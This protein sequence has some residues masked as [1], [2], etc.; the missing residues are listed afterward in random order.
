M[1]ERI[2]GI[3]IWRMLLILVAFL[4]HWRF[5]DAFPFLHLAGGVAVNAFFIIGGYFF[6][7]NAQ[8]NGAW[9]TLKKTFFRVMP[10]VVVSGLLF[11]L[12]TN[13]MLSEISYRTIER[14][15]LLDGSV[16]NNGAAGYPIAWFI[17]A[18]FWALAAFAGII[19]LFEKKSKWIAGAVVLLSFAFLTQGGEPTRFFISGYDD[20]G[21]AFFDLLRIPMIRAL[22]FTGIGVLVSGIRFDI[23]KK[24]LATLLQLLAFGF[25]IKCLL[26]GYL[27][28]D[29]GMMNIAFSAA[30][31]AALIL[32]AENKD[33][34]SQ[35]MNFI[36]K[37]ATLI[38]RY[39]LFVYVFIICAMHVTA[40]G[41][42]DSA[43]NGLEALGIA[44]ALAVAYYHAE[45]FVRKK[46]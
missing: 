38:S 4:C 16:L 46:L 1:K 42:R 18:Y 40:H 27:T 35:A 9:P 10:V 12:M 11:D 7:T 28:S 14:L 34:I 37:K 30:T 5:T 25:V 43:L 17:P 6:F 33:Y 29:R 22:C 13:R 24:W 8:K 36:G 23:H 21:G 26:F 19:A 2:G 39:S 41:V 20:I 3:E 45:Q 15:L 44:I 32:F 31:V